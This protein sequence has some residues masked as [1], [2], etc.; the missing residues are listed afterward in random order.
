MSTAQ[1]LSDIILWA[2]VIIRL[3]GLRFGWKPG[4]LRSAI[5]VAM[6]STLNSDSVY[7]FVDGLLGEMNLLNLI[8]HLLLGWGLMDLSRLLLKATGGD[9]RQSR[10]VLVAGWILALLQVTLL[11]VS[12]TPGS[13]TNFTDTFGDQPTIALYSA[14]FFAWIGFICAH[15]GIECLRRDKSTESRSFRA[16]FDTLIWACLA[17]VLGVAAKMVLIGIELFTGGGG[18][19]PVKDGIHTAYLVFVALTI[20]GFAVSFSVSTAGRIML[21][22]T[23]LKERTAAMT[24]LRPIVRRLVQTPE[25]QK[26][27]D[28]AKISLQARSSRTQLYRWLILIGD[29]TVLNPQVLTPGEAAI[30]DEVGEKF[31]HYTASSSAAAAGGL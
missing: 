19:G 31:E 16:G 6:A 18:E 30:V 24:A 5:L 15:T 2:V 17:G 4:I 26:S 25:G 3:V 13:A 11:A 1:L 23:E 22:L 7:L 20:S 29:C 27:V 28:A 9:R 8:V 10:R 12:D 21:S 14:T